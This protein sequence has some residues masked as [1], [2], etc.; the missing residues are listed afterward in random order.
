MP[1]AVPEL[2]MD[3]DIVRGTASLARGSCAA[4]RTNCIA[5][6]EPASGWARGLMLA[7]AWTRQRA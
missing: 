7:T 5:L 6:Y 3:P 2:V 1:T 4:R